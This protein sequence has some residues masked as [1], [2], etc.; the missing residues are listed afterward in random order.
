MPVANWLDYFV[1]DFVHHVANRCFERLVFPSRSLPFSSLDR[2]VHL[3]V[4]TEKG[5]KDVLCCLRVLKQGCPPWDD[6]IN[7]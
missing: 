4:D 5:L 3:P 6:V 2:F 1:K 7:S